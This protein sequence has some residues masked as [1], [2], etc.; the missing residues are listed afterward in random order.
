MKNNLIK[1]YTTAFFFCAT[2]AAF[3]APGDTNDTND[4]E[5]VDAPAPIDDYILIV[6]VLA[7]VLVFLKYRS[8]SK[9]NA[10]SN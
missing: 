6:G 5:T 4:L 2:F 9:Q 7:L 10:L 3:A 1:L 8:V